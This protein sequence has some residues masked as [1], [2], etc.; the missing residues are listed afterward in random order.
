MDRRHVVVA[1][2][3][4]GTACSMP[5]RAGDGPLGIDHTTAYD[6]HGLWKR[7]NQKTLE[8]LLIGGEIAG[9][10]WEGSDT[11]LGDTLYRSIDASVIG[12]VST[13]V[14]KHAFRRLR[15]TETSD[16]NEW[17]KHG[18]RSFP[19]GEVALATGVVTPIILEYGHD[20]PAVYSLAL[21]PLYD[22]IARVKVHG[23]WQTDILA[24]WAIGSATG[25]Y[26]HSR[27]Q[28]ITV[29]ILPRGLTVGWRTTF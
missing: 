11:R 28:S 16:P 10:L 1:G 7:S 5:A 19:S 20:N 24:G 17:F 12:A 3:I 27:G 14:L 6:N 13:E 9:A 26:A 18:G 4:A 29:G 8:G 25:Y 15:P 22:G 21:L 23:H 2:L